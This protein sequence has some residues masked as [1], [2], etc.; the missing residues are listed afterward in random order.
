VRATSAQLLTS[1]LTLEFHIMFFYISS[2]L[3]LKS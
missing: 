2:R 3:L 1:F